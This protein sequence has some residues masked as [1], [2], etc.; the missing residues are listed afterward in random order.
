[1]KACR[2]FLG[3]PLRRVDV[4][5]DN[6]D[7]LLACVL[8]QGGEGVV[9]D[10]R[11]QQH[12]GLAGDCSLHVGGLLLDRALS[13]GEDH[14]AIRLNLAAGVVETLLDG[15]PEGVR[16]RGMDGEGDL[17]ARRLGGAGETQCEANRAR[18]Q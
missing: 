1:M 6:R 8:Q 16:R 17:H 9:V 11:G 7:A 4:H 12:V 14:L 10:N 15:L 5:A 13:L 2:A 3:G 18:S